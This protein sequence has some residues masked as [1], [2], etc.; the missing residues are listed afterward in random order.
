MAFSVASCHRHFFLSPG[1]SSSR[2]GSGLSAREDL[3]PGRALPAASLVAKTKTK[4]KT[5]IQ[6]KATAG[7]GTE[8]GSLGRSSA[9]DGK[10]QRLCANSLVRLSRRANDRLRAHPPGPAIGGIA[11]VLALILRRGPS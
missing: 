8:F 2:L 3:A 10:K 4:T 5:K 1:C 6:D 9:G 7:S 11:P